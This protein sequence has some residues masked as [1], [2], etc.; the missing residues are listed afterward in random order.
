MSSNASFNAAIGHDDHAVADMEVAIRLTVDPEVKA[1]SYSELAKI[2]QKRRD[3]S[4]A[5]EAAKVN[6][7]CHRLFHAVWSSY[8]HVCFLAQDWFA[9]SPLPVIR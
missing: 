1:D 3:H 7:C 9:Q 4:K 8:V 6:I 5:E 2:H